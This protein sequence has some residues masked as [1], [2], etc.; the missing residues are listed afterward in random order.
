MTAQ[1]SAATGMPGEPQ[2]EQPARSVQTTWTYTLSSI[3]FFFVVLDAILLIV[4]MANY[5]Q[6]RSALDAILLA[7]LIVSAVVQVRYCW[8]LRVGRGGGMPRVGWTVALFAPPALA[9]V[10]G[11]F[12]PAAGLF[13]AFPL[14]MAV[15]AVAP[16]LPV[17]SRRAVL[18][19]GGVVTVLHPVL[20]SMLGHP[21]D[22]TGMS[23]SGLLY[24][25]GV[26]LP[27]MILSSLWWWEI[28]VTLDRHRSAAAELAVAKE[29]LR[30][31]SDLHDIQGHHLQVIALKSELAER[32]LAVDPEA[33]REHVHETRMIA[34]QA[35]EETR[36]LV[37]G[38][39]EVDLAAELEN[40]REVL[41]AAGADCTLQVDALPADAEVRRVL[42]LVVR[43][44]TTNILRHSAATRAAIRLTTTAESVTLEIENNEAA[45]PTDAAGRADS[46]GLVG[47]RDRV[48]ALNGRLETDVESGRF[49]LRVVV[50][51]RIGARV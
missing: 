2:R 41:T 25:Y 37:A 22:T 6:S 40:A 24:F 49:S 36:S 42:A 32:L 7:L 20:A 46:S 27:L 9:W 30:F 33:A 13:A 43:E 45:V 34:K 44:A 10:L 5:A 8:F 19:A 16:L 50:P 51:A 35:L 21:F 17:T 31:A 15:N 4:A 11:L 18:P 48:S 29:R 3:I 12:T 47:L 14:W 38:Y 28:V 1:R 39:R 26:L 23:G